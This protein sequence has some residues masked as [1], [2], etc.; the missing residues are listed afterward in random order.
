[1]TAPANLITVRRSMYATLGARNDFVSAL[2]RTCWDLGVSLNL[3]EESGWFE[4]IYYASFTGLPDTV[5][6][7]NQTISAWTRE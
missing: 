7:V 2:K 4:T 5:N 1:M 3:V 6:R